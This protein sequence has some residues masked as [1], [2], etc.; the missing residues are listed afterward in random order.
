MGISGA[1]QIIPNTSG[2]T[3][4]TAGKGAPS[5][6]GPTAPRLAAEAA[7]FPGIAGRSTSLLRFSKRKESNEAGYE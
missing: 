6:R 2:L 7:P 4:A 5:S 3:G 1:R